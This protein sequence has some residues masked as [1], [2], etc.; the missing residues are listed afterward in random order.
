M[1]NNNLEEIKKII[2]KLYWQSSTIADYSARKAWENSLTRSVCLDEFGSEIFSMAKSGNYTKQDIISFTQKYKS[3]IDQLFTETS[4][5][6]INFFNKYAGNESIISLCLFSNP[7]QIDEKL[8]KKL[9][10]M[11]KYYSRK[12]ST[13][14]SRLHGG[15]AGS[16]DLYIDGDALIWFLS[17]TALSGFLWDITKNKI[18]EL[19]YKAKVYSCKLTNES[20]LHQ[21]IALLDLSAQEVEQLSEHWY[22]NYQRYILSLSIKE[23]HVIQQLISHQESEEKLLEVPKVLLE[24]EYACTIESNSEY[25]YIILKSVT[26]DML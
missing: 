14:W 26:Y 17:T 24:I 2:V 8:Q 7:E 20:E 19:L 21:R 5:D 11:Q 12:Q 15:S 25:L 22:T 18:S 10:Y 1:S 4:S 9:F 6:F 23:R 13:S 3:R 16:A